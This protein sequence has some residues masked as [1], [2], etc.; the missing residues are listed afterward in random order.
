LQFII[1]IV[2]GNEARVVLK[3]SEETTSNYIN[4]SFVDVSILK[5]T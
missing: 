4:A 1:M 3:N 2:T 5:F